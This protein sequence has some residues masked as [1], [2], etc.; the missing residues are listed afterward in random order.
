M[1]M[2]LSPEVLALVVLAHLIKFAVF[3]AISK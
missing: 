1:H 3:I 2:D